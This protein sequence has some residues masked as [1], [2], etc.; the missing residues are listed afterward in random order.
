MYHLRGDDDHVN[1]WVMGR[2]DGLMVQPS[3]AKANAITE[4]AAAD[5]DAPFTANVCRP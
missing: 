4:G 3:A 2:F 5:A 1:N